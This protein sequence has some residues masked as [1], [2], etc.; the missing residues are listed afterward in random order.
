[1]TF[2]GGPRGCIGCYLGLM[3]LKVTIAVILCQFKLVER[4]G[5]GDG[6]D[7]ER[8]AFLVITRPRVKGDGGGALMPLR[9]SYIKYHRLF[10]YTK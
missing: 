8:L 10:K 9:I 3:E 5:P 4:D 2:L 6:S 1:M 7:F